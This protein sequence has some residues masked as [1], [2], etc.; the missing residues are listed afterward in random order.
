MKLDRWLLILALIGAA[1]WYFF[2]RD[3]FN[4]VIGGADSMLQNLA[5]AIT[6]HESGGDPNALNYRNNNPGNLRSPNGNSSFWQGQTGVD[7]QGFAIFDSFAN[8][9]RALLMNLKIKATQ[10]PNWNLQNLFA[11]WLG[12]PDPTRPEITTEGNP[13]TYA[14]DVAKQIGKSVSTTL[15]DLLKAG[16]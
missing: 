6:Q 13:F 14:A 10:H 9:M 12:N 16:A 1:V 3:S 4:S 11:N 5:D 7:G 8:G 2:Y 15:G